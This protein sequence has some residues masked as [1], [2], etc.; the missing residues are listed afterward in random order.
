M[1]AQY[2]HQVI[3]ATIAKSASVTTAIPILGFNQIAIEL[4]GTTNLV[5]TTP[6]IFV[7]VCNTS[8]GT[9]RRVGV[10]SGGTATAVTA[11]DWCIPGT[12]GNRIYTCQEV[13][14]YKYLKIESS[15]SATATAGWAV[16]VHGIM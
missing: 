7:Q 5:S 4:P 6:D 16:V 11:V 15:V 1:Y 2:G 9:F 13:I 10:I 3:S 14:G 12:T 8:T